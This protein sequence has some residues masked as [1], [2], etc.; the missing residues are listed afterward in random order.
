MGTV[1]R[2]DGGHRCTSTLTHRVWFLNK[3]ILVGNGQIANSNMSVLVA[4]IMTSVILSLKLRISQTL[5][6]KE[7]N[8]LSISCL[9]V[10]YY[11]VSCILPVCPCSAAVP[12]HSHTCGGGSSCRL[13]S[14]G[15]ALPCF[16]PGTP[17]AWP[18]YLIH[19][20]TEKRQQFQICHVRE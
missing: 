12:L 8:V 10:L 14:G 9:D 11:S 6:N 7:T 20:H 19:T 17:H 18:L 16:L 13:C 4:I 15:R 3:H 2:M 5:D 1:T